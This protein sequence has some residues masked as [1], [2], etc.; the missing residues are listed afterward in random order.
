M[1]TWWPPP[2]SALADGPPPAFTTRYLAH[3]PRRNRMRDSYL[4]CASEPPARSAR[5]VGR[6]SPSS[7]TTAR[8]IA[9]RSAPGVRL[10]DNHGCT[11]LEATCARDIAVGDPVL[12]DRQRILAAGTEHSTDDT[13]S[14]SAAAARALRRGS[15][16]FGSS[17]TDG[18]A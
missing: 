15:D 5:R 11:R 6:F 9:P 16:Q 8:C 14:G 2:C 18:V 7:C 4:A 12:S 3:Y 17:D 10:R 13:A 1:A